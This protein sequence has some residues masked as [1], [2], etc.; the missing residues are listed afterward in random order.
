LALFV[1]VAK[2]LSFN[3]MAKKRI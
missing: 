1:F 3:C 2:P